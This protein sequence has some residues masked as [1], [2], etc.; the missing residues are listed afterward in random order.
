MGEAEP[1]VETRSRAP[2]PTG[3]SGSRPLRRRDE[4]E[5][6][7]EPV[8]RDSQPLSRGSVLARRAGMGRAATSAELVYEIDSA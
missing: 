4:P 6:R 5:V 3:A 7:I 2:R 1:A 8:W